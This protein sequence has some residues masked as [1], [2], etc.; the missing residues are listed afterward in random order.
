MVSEEANWEKIVGQYRLQVGAALSPLRK[1]GQATYVDG[2]SEELVQ[3]AIQLHFKLSGAD[4]P[5]NVRDI[6]W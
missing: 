2:V 5:F 6:H 1:Y 3:L 4:I